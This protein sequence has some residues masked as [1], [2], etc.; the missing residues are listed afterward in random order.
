MSNC[1]C[2]CAARMAASAGAF[3]PAAER[4]GLM[5]LI[6]RW[7]VDTVLTQFLPP[8]DGAGIE[9]RHQPVRRQP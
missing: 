7:V 6:D 4:Y 1:C 5:P 2:G 3:L 8:P 9:L